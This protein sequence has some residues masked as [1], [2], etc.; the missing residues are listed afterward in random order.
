MH[1]TKKTKILY[2]ITKSNWGGAQRYVY[3]LATSLPDNFEVSVALG[4]DGA[5]K[6]KLES[7]RIRVIPLPWLKRD[8]NFFADFFVF[9]HLITLFK[10]ERPDI[11]HVNSSKIGGL[12]ALAGRI[13]KVPKIIFTAHGWAF[14]E[15]RPEFQ[16]VI[17]KFLSWLTI[18]FSHKVITVSKRDEIEGNAMPFSRKKIVLI[19]NGIEDLAFLSKESA[20]EKILKSGQITPGGVEQLSDKTLWIGTIGELHTNKGHIFAL[21]ALAGW[22]TS[23]GFIFCIIGEGEEQKALE[24][25]ARDLGIFSKIIFLGRREDATELLHAFDLFLCPSIKEGLPYAI[26]EASVAKLPIIASSVGGIPEV[27]DDMETGILVR[28]K[29]PEELHRAFE[30]FQNHHQKMRLFG[31][32]LATKV[33][34]KFSFSKMK[35]ETLAIYTKK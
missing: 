23:H 14:R 17:I 33:K 21:E 5:L 18:L 9:K 1:N 20:R 24:D 4:G 2:V 12:G 22:N 16:K 10:T 7:A 31:Q 25:K 26:L 19:N 6:T 34:K 29:S 15:E 32:K 3:N 8:V 28:P 30:Y 35:K 13:A 27:I 11:I